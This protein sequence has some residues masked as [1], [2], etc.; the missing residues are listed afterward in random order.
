MTLPTRS[1]GAS[2]LEVGAIGLGCMSFSGVYGG[3]EGHDPDEVIGRALDL[4]VTLLDTADVYGPHTSERVVGK[5]IAGR[6]EG[7]VL[8]TKF[9]L[10][11]GAGAIGLG[12]DGSPEHARESIDGS[13]ERLGV[14]H[15]DLYYLHRPDTTVPIEESVGAM[16][17]MVTAGKVRHLGLS[18]A[19]SDT[20]RRAHAV[21][22]IAVLQTEYSLW[23]R[24]IEPDILPTCREL[25]IGLVPYSP[26]GR[27]FLTGALSSTD[28]LAP[29]DMRRSHPRFQ[30]GALADVRAAVDTV[31]SVADA[32]G[33]TLGQVALAWILS[34]GDDVVPIPG[35]KRVAYVEQN[36][37]A[38][39]VE[40]SAEDLERLDGISVREPRTFDEGWINR[41]TP[42]A[43]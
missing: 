24:D 2:G 13:L 17:E 19:S 43:G 32:H 40:L 36:V 22:P 26:L 34:R 28:G 7:V 14:D 4:G 16:G 31:Q 41:S 39:D 15:V 30:D 5:A 42:A 3:F 18:E 29:T 9:G 8:A 33:A 10:V 21:H 35:T 27:G 20:L 6:R 12:V 38:A 23:S 25:G 11:P 1:L 37:A